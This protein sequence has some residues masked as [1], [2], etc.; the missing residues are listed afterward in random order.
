MCLGLKGALKRL[1]FTLCCILFSLHYILDVL[2]QQI[3]CALYNIH[4]F[5]PDLIHRWFYGDDTIIFNFRGG[6]N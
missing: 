6:A 3:L 4:S 5:L 1:I 2:V